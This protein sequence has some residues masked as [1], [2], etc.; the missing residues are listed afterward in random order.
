MEGPATEPYNANRFATGGQDLEMS[1]KPGEAGGRSGWARLVAFG[2]LGAFIASVLTVIYTGLMVEGSSSDFDASFRS[3]TLA[4]GETR[5]IELYFEAAAAAPDA[6]LELILPAGI[7]ELVGGTTEQPAALEAGD[8]RLVV[9]LR[10]TEP[11]QGYLVARVGAATQI[12]LE[13]V[14]LTVVEAEGG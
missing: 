9:T 8:N 7:V 10:A 4:V 2:F 13:R 5:E 14:F 3:I 12:G 11:G 6:R 1:A